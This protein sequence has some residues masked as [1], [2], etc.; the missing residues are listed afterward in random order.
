M[1]APQGC[2]EEVI[3]CSRP[4]GRVT[5]KEKKKKSSMPVSVRGWVG[6]VKG[7]FTRSIAWKKKKIRRLLKS[8]GIF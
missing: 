5:G 7:K 1:P 3:L 6:G 4:R 2:E 8:D